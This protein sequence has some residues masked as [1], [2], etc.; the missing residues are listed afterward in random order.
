MNGHTKNRACLQVEQLESRYAPSAATTALTISPPTSHTNSASN[1]DQVAVQGCT[2]GI[3]QHAATAS[4][5]VVTCSL[6]G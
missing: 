1:A 4:N 2:S 3:S 6:V 5:G